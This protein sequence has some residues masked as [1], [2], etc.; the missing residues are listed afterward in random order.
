MAL[1]Q[2]RADEQEAQREKEAQ[3]R[4]KQPN[5]MPQ[6]APRPQSKQP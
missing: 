1:A 2:K 4:A 3:T 6:K 5:V